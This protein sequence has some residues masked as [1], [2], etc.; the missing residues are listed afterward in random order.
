MIANVDAAVASEV[1]GIFRDELELDVGL[2][3]DVIESGVL[4]SIGF[5]QLLVALEERFG[6][7][8]DV[9]DLELDDFSSVARI[10][11]FVSGQ[12]ARARAPR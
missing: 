2:D 1:H 8:V 4:D 11:E 10:A 7:T 3:T 5:V 6:V 9:A 12:R